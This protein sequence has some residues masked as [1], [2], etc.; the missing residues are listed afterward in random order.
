MERLFHRVSE[1]T[2]N[3]DSTVGHHVSGVTA[4][5]LLAQGLHGLGSV[6]PL[7]GQRDLACSGTQLVEA[8]NGTSASLKGAMLM[9]TTGF[10]GLLEAGKSSNEP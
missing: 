6:T 3:D 9:P 5:P 1:A 10:Q 4:S 7:H 2:V 8:G